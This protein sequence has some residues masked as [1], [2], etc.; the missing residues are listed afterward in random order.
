MWR[1]PVGEGAKRV[2]SGAAGMR[3]GVYSDSQG[4]AVGG[5]NGH[6]DHLQSC[7][8][9]HGMRVLSDTCSRS[10][11]RSLSPWAAFSL[12]QCDCAGTLKKPLAALSRRGGPSCPTFKWTHCFEFGMASARFTIQRGFVGRCHCVNPVES[13]GM[14]ANS[15]EPRD[16]L[17]RRGDHGDHLARPARRAGRMGRR[18]WRGRLGRRWWRGRLGRRWWVGRRGAALAGL[19]VACCASSGSLT[20]GDSSPSLSSLRS[21]PVPSGKSR[22]S[23]AAIHALSVSTSVRLI[24]CSM[25]WG[26]RAAFTRSPL[27]VPRRCGRA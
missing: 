1:C 22:G 26:I 2:T 7:T 23:P 24:D 17:D 18:W 5:G 3:G 9:D 14:Y 8:L 16:P 4:A 13:E 25:D 27:R 15:R 20:V 10:V 21:I 11:C 19:G 6:S 12:Y